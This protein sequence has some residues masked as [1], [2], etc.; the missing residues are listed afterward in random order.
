VGAQVQASDL[1]EANAESCISAAVARWQFPAAPGATAVSYP[2]MF[3][4]S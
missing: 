3:Q 2:F 1:H 4:S